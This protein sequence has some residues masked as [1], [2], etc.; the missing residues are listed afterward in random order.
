M[1]SPWYSESM[2]INYRR[3]NPLSPTIVSK[4]WIPWDNAGL[5]HESRKERRLADAV[6]LREALAGNDSA[7]F[8]PSR[9]GNRWHWD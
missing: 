7:L 3:K 1:S 5:R 4:R 8:S 9:C 2:K 6:A